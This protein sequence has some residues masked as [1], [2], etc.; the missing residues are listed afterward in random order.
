MGVY[1]VKPA[2]R[3]LLRGSARA[4]AA[5]G[6]TPDQ[7]T[8]AGVVASA[9]GGLAFGAARRRPRVYAAVPALA[10][11]RTAANALDGLVA[12][13]AGMSR[14]AGE[15]WNE[16]ADRIGDAAFLAGAA[17]VPGVPP[18]LAASA[19]AAAEL[20]SFVGVTAKAAG[21]KR[22]YDGPMGKPDRMLVLGAAG[23]V[24]AFVK[25]PAWVVNTGLAVIGAGAV[26]TAA[27]RY[28]LAHAELEAAHRAG[29]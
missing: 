14:P 23:L 27:N 24:A 9:L 7:V 4:L 11:V 5:Q 21:G 17:V 3:K 20:S 15:L 1:A 29:A 22:H 26:A 6:V 8:A 12:E 10:F 16:T 19:L 25:R 2:F 13:E 18:V 28:R